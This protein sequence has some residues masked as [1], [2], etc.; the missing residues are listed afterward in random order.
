MLIGP[1]RRKTA[2]AG[3]HG[4]GDDVAHAFDFTGIGGALRGSVTQNEGAH[5]RM[6]NETGDV[7][8]HAFLLQHVEVLRK[9]LET[10]VDALAQGIERHAFDVGQIT[11]GQIAVIRPARRDGE[12]AIPHDQRRHAQRR[13]RIGKRVPGDLRVI[14]RVRVDDPGHQGKRSSVDVLARFGLEM[15]DLADPAV[16][17]TNRSTTAGFAA[18]VVNRRIVNAQIKHSRFLLLNFQDTGPGSRLN[19]VSDFQN[20]ECGRPGRP[21]PGDGVSRFR[22]KQCLCQW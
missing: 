19:R 17:D 10:P 14:V 13:R 20:L 8:P 6:P 15:S 4:L 9:R 2:G 21:V 16:L 7:G 18:A 11:H 5:A 3:L 1:G 22:A 12:S